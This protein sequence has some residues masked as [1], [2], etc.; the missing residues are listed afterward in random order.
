M[1]YMIGAFSFDQTRYPAGAA[2]RHYLEYHAPLARPLP[3]LGEVRHRQGRRDGADPG[4]V[5]AGGRPGVRLL[6]V[7]KKRGSLDQ[8]APG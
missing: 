1:F 5:A 8:P 4:G 6:T 3:G 2:K 7:T